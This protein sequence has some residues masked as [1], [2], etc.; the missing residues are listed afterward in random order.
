MKT[1]HTLKRLAGAVIFVLVLLWAACDPPVVVVD[2]PQYVD[3]HAI[4]EANVIVERNTK[5]RVSISPQIEIVIP[6]KRLLNHNCSPADFDTCWCFGIKIPLGWEVKDSIS[7]EGTQEGNFIYSDEL[8]LM[9]MDS[10]PPGQGYFWWA[11][12]SLD[13]YS[14]Q[15]GQI[16]FIPEIHASGQSGN[17]YLDYVFGWPN[18]PN[19]SWNSGNYIG[20]G[21]SDTVYVTS[22]NNSGT[23]S[24][25]AAIDSVV[26]GGHIFFVLPYSGAI[27]LDDQI[28][29]YKSLTIHGP[30]NIQLSVSGNNQN[31]VFN[32]NNNLNV[33][34][35]D[36]TISDGYTNADGGGICCG[37]SSIVLED[38][39]IIANKAGNL[40]GGIY[41][42]GTLLLENSQ[43]SNNQARVGGGVYGLDTLEIKG[44]TIKNNLA[45]AGGGGIFFK[46]R[47]VF[48]SLAL[49]NIYDNSARIG[50][51]L[52]NE[53]APPVI[54]YL[55]NYTVKYPN[56]YFTFPVSSFN[57]SFNNYKHE[58]NQATMYVSAD[59]SDENSGLSS[60]QP[61]KTISNALAWIHGKNN[62]P[63]NIR[64]APGTYG[65]SF[66]Y[67]Y[68]TLYCRSHVSLIGS[69]N[70]TVILEAVTINIRDAENLKVQNIRLTNSNKPVNCSNSSPVLKNLHIFNNDSYTGAVS[71]NYCSGFIIDNIEMY[72]NYIG[73]SITSSSGTIKNSEISNNRTGI[74]AVSSLLTMQ[75]CNIHNHSEGAVVLSG[76]SEATLDY[77]QIFENYSESGAAVYMDE[78]SKAILSGS[79]IRNNHATVKGGGIYN[80]SGYLV[81]DDS[82]R[83]SIYMNEAPLGADIYSCNAPQLI[84]VIVDTFSVAC[85]GPYF[86]CWMSEFNFDILHG[87]YPQYNADIYVSPEGSD[88]NSGFTP[89]NPLKTITKALKSICVN[90]DQHTIHLAPGEYSRTLTGE[91]FPLLCNNKINIAG[92]DGDLVTIKG[93]Q[94]NPVFR[95]EGVSDFTLSNINITQGSNGIAAYNSDFAMENIQVYENRNLSAS[96][97][98]GGIRMEYSDIVMNNVQINNNKATGHLSVGGG[99]YIF[100]ECE[101]ITD[102]LTINGNEAFYGGGIYI[103]HAH[104]SLNN[105]YLIENKAFYS[106]SYYLASGGGIYCDGSDVL[107][108]NIHMEKNIA[109]HNGGGLVVEN[110]SPRISNVVI[111][112]NRSDFGG[113]IYI[114]NGSPVISNA[115]IKQNRAYDDGAGVWISSSGARF[116]NVAFYENTAGNCGGGMLLDSYAHPQV[117]RCLFRKNK[118]EYGAGLFLNGGENS[119]IYGTRIDSNYA[120]VDGGGLYLAKSM[121]PF[122]TST[123]IAANRANRGGG[124]FLNNGAAPFVPGS[125]IKFNSAEYGGG[126]YFSNNSRIQHSG[127]RS[128]IYLNSTATGGADLYAENCTLIP[129]VVDTFTVLHPTDYFA[130]ERDT[131]DFDILNFVLE[132]GNYD[133][134]VSPNGSDDN[135]GISPESPLL[136]LK[137]ARLKAITDLEEPY[138]IH[139]APGTYSSTVPGEEFP[140]M[141]SSH[142]WL[143]GESMNNTFIHGNNNSQLCRVQ[144]SNDFLVKNLSFRNGWA[145]EGGA[146]NI[147]DGAARFEMVQI[148]DSWGESGGGMFISESEVEMDDVAILNNSSKKGGGIY[149]TGNS[150]IQGKDILIAGNHTDNYGGG[151]GLY[152]YRYTGKIQNLNLVNNSAYKGGGMYL[153]EGAPVLYNAVISSNEAS[154]FGG[155][156]YVSACDSLK[157]NNTTFSANSSIMGGAVEARNVVQLSIKNSIIWDNSKYEISLFSSNL[158]IGH[159]DVKGDSSNI[160]VYGNYEMKWLEGNINENPLFSLNPDH[161]F[162]L[163][164]GSPCIDAGTS[165]TLGLDLPEG[166]I[167][168]NN[169]IFDG[170]GV[171]F[172]I[173]DMGA[174]EFGSI[175]VGNTD[176]LI[177]RISGEIACYP[178]PADASAGIT[179]KLSNTGK[180]KISIFS[181][182]GNKELIL[183]DEIQQQG[184]HRFVFNT[185]GLDAGIY[186]VLLQAENQVN[187]V[188]LMILH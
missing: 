116:N 59:G 176:Q 70:D 58:Q 85:P 16:H 48:D 57:F 179:Y 98:G 96:G 171:G 82:I 102:S 19:G 185:G 92:P 35:S 121:T 79:S 106:G 153:F 11:G 34:I 7:F 54:L 56:D 155:G 111:I 181:V 72:E 99:L 154:N 74:N 174:Y 136:T 2:Q 88:Q 46:G 132:Q 89:E 36:L 142:I 52:Y 120:T 119:S 167:L 145:S 107:L 117:M 40:G 22:F 148:T 71:L 129:I 134:Y 49:S 157:I 175:P 69:E 100:G 143:I 110:C 103:D 125:T 141:G 32:V 67:E 123:V 130:F 163:H 41:T 50:Y 160:Y 80:E 184:I 133:V 150:Y 94:N 122:F 84:D 164:E 128:N 109:V 170:S 152:G 65:P 76:Q 144:G 18:M 43:I 20:V 81:F 146:I 101:L 3:K 44:S 87:I 51:D 29:I 113:G 38:V 173:I 66:N 60:A 95:M 86:S 93:D 4:F 180:V 15:N 24:L 131:F 118:A 37:K 31:R 186:L 45:H 178:N 159:S 6:E 97:K 5:D 23:G 78:S 14:Q 156:I 33:Y 10:C 61:K 28:D 166:D 68:E 25:R 162:S 158:E 63:Q 21:L 73:L 137:A 90:Q 187:T 83:P 115:E 151:G 55:N 64:I 161:P 188:K 12:K 169:R 140:F 147:H 108:G 182:Q 183:A 139:L 17:F 39:S 124:L 9:M 91:N 53:Y 114:H 165:D 104:V 26:G 105:I 138:V 177:K 77:C 13:E 30:E 135:S 27:F 8:S 172:A 47:L 112:D 1:N 168:G 126:I 127:T 149:S 75:D 42:Q 62:Y